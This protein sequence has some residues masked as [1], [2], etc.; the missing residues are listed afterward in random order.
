MGTRADFYIG[1][2][3]QA[4]WIGSI[5]FDGYPS[6]IDHDAF[7]VFRA[8]T[9]DSYRAA[10]KAM[11]A[12]RGD[13]TLPPMGWPWPWN[14]SGTTDYAYAFDGGT[15]YG[16]CFGAPW[17]EVRAGDPDDGTETGP[18]PTFPD[19]S[20][21]KNVAYGPRSGVIIVSPPAVSE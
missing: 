1:R 11:F 19:M 7:A 12:D 10:V 17:F 4:E 5:A 13:V 6:G 9:E 21:Y 3:D 20:A 14:D 18:T 2:T 15:V 16:S 8:T